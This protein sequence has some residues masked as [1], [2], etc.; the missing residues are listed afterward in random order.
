MQNTEPEVSLPHKLVHVAVGVIYREDSILIAKRSDNAHQGG[1]WEFPGGKVES[2]ESVQEALARELKEELGITLAHPQTGLSPLI[3]IRHDYGD[4][5]VLLDVWSV[6]EFSGDPTGLEGQPVKWVRESNLREFE[7][8]A[9]NE[10]IIRAIELPSIY[11]VTPV[12]SSLDNA[13]AYISALIE[14]EIDLILFR[15]PQL[16]SNAYLSWL[17]ALQIDFPQMR[18]VLSGDPCLLL[19]HAK[20]GLQIPARYAEDFLDSVTSSNTIVS[21]P[22]LSMSCHS[23]AELELAQ[24]IGVDFVCLSPVKPTQSHPN[25]NAMGWD[26]F[27]SLL[28][29]INVPVYALGGMQPRDKAIAQSA[30]AQGIAGISTWYDQNEHVEK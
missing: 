7:F 25:A 22:L 3:Q 4:K 30:G 9:A 19:P 5:R 14:K 11:P 21:P 8:P 1:L 29:S 28:K 6:F 24:R 27:Q 18:F 13:Y 2:N 16:S 15:Q 10:P 17:H 23:L 20:I 12:F 26:R